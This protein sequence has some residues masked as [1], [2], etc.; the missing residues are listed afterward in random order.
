[1][2]ICNFATSSD[3]GNSGGGANFF[4]FPRTPVEDDLDWLLEEDVLER[5][6]GVLEK[7]T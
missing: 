6:D 4:L 3:F 7:I 5:V 1:L 2:N